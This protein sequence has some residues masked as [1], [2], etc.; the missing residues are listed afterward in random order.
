MA[1]PWRAHTSGIRGCRTANASLY[2]EEKRWL[3]TPRLFLFFSFPFF[4]PVHT[5]RGLKSDPGRGAVHAHADTGVATATDGALGGL[6]NAD[7]DLHLATKG[8]LNH[9]NS[10]L[11]LVFFFPFPSSFFSIPFNAL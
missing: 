9:E 4:L 7:H 3:T 5:S 8:K 2:L 6:V 10:S 11:P 1:L